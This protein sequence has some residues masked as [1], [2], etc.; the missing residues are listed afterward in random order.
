[1]D[2][3]A[4]LPGIK[5]I[6]MLGLIGAC[7]NSSSQSS[8]EKP[9]NGSLTSSLDGACGTSAKKKSSKDESAEG[10]EDEK[11]DSTDKKKSSTKLRLAD[12]LDPSY[13]GGISDLL[14]KHCVQ[15]HA[16]Y[17]SYK[18]ASADGKRIVSSI[19]NGSMPPGPDLIPEQQE[20]F[21][22][23]LDDGFPEDPKPKS[24]SNSSEGDEESDEEGGTSTSPK[25]GTRKSPSSSSSED[26]DSN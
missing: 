19:K 2:H 21:Q 16:A 4:S 17:K 24:K 3:I 12:D 26:C 22:S 1:M 6:L 20:L 14:E 7:N 23:W 8:I 9:R 13:N 15:C 25:V 5:L 11:E 10:D 18:G